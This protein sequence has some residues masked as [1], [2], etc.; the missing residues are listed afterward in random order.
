MRCCLWAVTGLVLLMG[1][2]GSSTE[3]VAEV[4]TAP[5]ESPSSAA[6]PVP[7]VEAR[8][9]SAMPSEEARSPAPRGRFWLLNEFEGLAQRFDSPTGTAFP[10]VAVGPST[11]VVASND[12]MAIFRKSGQLIDEGEPSSFFDVVSSDSGQGTAYQRVIFDV[13]SQRFIFVSAGRHVQH[14][15]AEPPCEL[16]DCIADVF[17]AVSK[18]DNPKTLTAADWHLYGFDWTLDNGTVTRN[19]ATMITVAVNAEAIVLAGASRNYPTEPYDYRPGQV[20]PSAEESYGKLRVLPLEPMLSGDPVDEWTDIVRVPDPRQGGQG[21]V[22]IFD[23]VAPTDAEDR[24]L[25]L[26]ER[27]GSCDVV[28]WEVVDPLGSASLRSK[29]AAVGGECIGPSE[30][31]RQHGDQTLFNQGGDTKFFGQPTGG[32]GSVW[33]ARTIARVIEGVE[34]TGT[35]WVE[36][37]V[38]RWPDEVSAAQQGTHLNA[39]EWHDFAAVVAD[40]NGNA[41]MVFRHSTAN[42]YPSL[43]FAGRLAGDPPGTLPDD[44]LLRAGESVHNFERAGYYSDA[45]LDPVDGTFWLTGQYPT[46]PGHDCCW[47]TWV[48][49]LS[50]KSRSP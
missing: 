30:L 14:L 48:A 5:S 11:V 18:D 40:G 21:F 4:G 13:G 39:G 6:L 43:H 27:G 25:M 47:S 22:R 36:L 45:A 50:V 24:L 2:S 35:H 38:S 1:C 42:S 19:F 28:V 12:R 10:T 29:T 9:P 8:S 15:Q 44:H 3:V 34:Y 37:D 46:E 41:A 32:D 49:Q 33:A 17:V 7:T 31:G 20:A 16:G 23:A 26:T